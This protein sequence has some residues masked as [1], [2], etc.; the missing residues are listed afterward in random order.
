MSPAVSHSFSCS[1]SILGLRPRAS[2]SGLCLSVEKQA[3]ILKKLS[4]ALSKS[5]GTA[6]ILT[7]NKSAL[8]RNSAQVLQCIHEDLPDHQLASCSRCV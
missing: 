1:D 4:A 7:D 2:N 6:L 5:T 3:K 8:V